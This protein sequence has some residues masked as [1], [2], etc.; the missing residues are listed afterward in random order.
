MKPTFFETIF[1]QIG[2]KFCFMGILSIVHDE[3]L[4]IKFFF[5]SMKAN[6]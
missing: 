1:D 6:F 5:Y 2:E 4:S 3:F